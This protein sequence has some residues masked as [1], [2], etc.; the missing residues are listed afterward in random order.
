MRKIDEIL[1]YIKD[2]VEL[3]DKELKSLDTALNYIEYETP[4]DL[5]LV[6]RRLDSIISVSADV[7]WTLAN[8]KKHRAKINAEYKALKDPQFTSLI[9]KG[10]PSTVA[11]ESEIRFID[12]NI[13]KYEY[14]IEVLDGF[15]EYLEYILKVLENI[16]WAIK[17]R[18]S[19][20]KI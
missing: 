18:V 14:R 13:A 17:D 5:P 11:I 6:F 1:E 20:S 10:R 7:S 12:D 9:R 19:L 3:G 15:I 4:T 8:V 2:E 16:Q